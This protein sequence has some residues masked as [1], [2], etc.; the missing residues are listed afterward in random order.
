MKMTRR[1]KRKRWIW[2]KKTPACT[3]TQ[4]RQ[5][6]TFASFVRFSCLSYLS[7]CSSRYFIRSHLYTSPTSACACSNFN[8]TLI[9]FFAPSLFKEPGEK[10][11]M[12][13][14]VNSVDREKD[15]LSVYFDVWFELSWCELSI[16]WSLI[17]WFIRRY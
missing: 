1:R 3:D 8:A 9:S 7:L 11:W 10:S 5:V 4:V 13:P 14:R 12:L 16:K 6:Q 15:Q 17:L 2:K